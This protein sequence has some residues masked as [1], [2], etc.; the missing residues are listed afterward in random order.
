MMKPTAIIC[1]WL[2]LLTACSVSTVDISKV[3]DG[4]PDI[5]PLHHKA[6]IPYNIAP[7]NFRYKGNCEAIRAEI[8][9]RNGRIIQ[10]GKGNKILFKS[11]E[12]SK[13]LKAHK[14]DSLLMTVSIKE[15]SGWTSF[16]PV[17]YH[18]SSDP[19]D[20]FLFYRLIM[21]GFQTWN[22]MGIYQRQLSGFDQ[23]T[24]LDSRL[25]P[26]TCMNCH[27]F[28]NKNPDNMLL[29]L[30]ENNGGTV[31]IRR[32]KVELLNTKTDRT[33]S[34]VAFPYW[35]P[36]GKYI[37]FSINKVRQMFHSIGHVRAH[38]L[39]M[40]SDMVIMDVD[41]NELFTSSL[42]FAD[43][44]FEA[45]PCFSPDGKTLYFVTAP[46][47]EM[48]ESMEQMKYSL[49]A[50]SFDAT[51][52]SI[53][54]KVDTLISAREINK[55][56]SIPRVSPDGRFL[57][58]CMF[59]YGN[60]PSYNPESDLYIFDLESRTYKNLEA[61]N[62]NNVE[63]Y[64][65]WSS[66]GRWI[67]FSSRRLDGLYSNVYLAHLDENGQAGVPFILPQEDPDFYS[68]FLFSFNIPEFATSPVKVS[69]Y[70]IE[71][72][73]KQGHEKQTSFGEIQIP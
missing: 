72:I 25:M 52:G 61:I 27:A 37:A 26:G 15:N 32:G 44:A 29:H 65:S 45:F 55:S 31:L 5:F 40:E 3:E 71:R 18:V 20:E 50:V 39:D 46:A 17:V 70:D 1:L 63:S 69:G 57:I 8:N 43:D 6:T 66:N 53:G 11:S 28:A 41:K 64:H 14:D 38:A 7:F 59:D 51:T 56:V 42:L 34:S 60:F 48:P 13:L 30:R 9:G 58:F 24:V 35:H 36:S 62:S 4:L 16:N 54:N 22:Q 33:F 12:W 21:P 10:H 67:A 2:I 23:K 73:A 49:C 19:V 47:K 68:N